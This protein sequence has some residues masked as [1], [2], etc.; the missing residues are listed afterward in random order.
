MPHLDARVPELMK[1]SFEVYDELQRQNPHTV[2]Y[3]TRYDRYS[4]TTPCSKKL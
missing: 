1:K 2:L 3:A 4:D